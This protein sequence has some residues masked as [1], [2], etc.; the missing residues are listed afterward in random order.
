MFSFKRGDTEGTNF[1]NQFAFDV[2]V[3]WFLFCFRFLFF[4]CLNVC[5][6]TGFVD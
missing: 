6:G 3:H 4:N 5:I 2:C 1:E